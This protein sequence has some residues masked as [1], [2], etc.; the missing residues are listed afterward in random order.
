M[1]VDPAD[2]VSRLESISEDLADMA[3]A[4]LRKAIEAGVE[5]DP[6]ERRLTQARRQVDKAASIL[7][8]LDGEPSE[9]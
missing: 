1:S 7:S 2:I 4:R 6:S 9:P 8:G 5:R 3:I